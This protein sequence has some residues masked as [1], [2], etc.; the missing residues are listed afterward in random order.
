VSLPVL[1]GPG[2]AHITKYHIVRPGKDGVEYD[3]FLIALPEREQLASF[4]KEVPLF[5]RYLKVVTDQEGRQPAFLAFLERAKSGLVVESDVFITTEELL[6]LMWKNGYSEQ[7]RNAVQFTFPADYKFHYPELSVLFDI[8]EEDTYKFAMRTRIESSH[9]GELDYAK[10]KPK[11]MLRDHWLIFGTGLFIFKTFPFF[12][13]YFGVKVF[14]TSM[15]CWTVWSLL[16]RFV[17]KITRRNEYMAAQKTAQDVM[18]GEDAIV[19]SMRRFANDAK[20]VE[21]LKTFKD[22]TDAKIGHYRKALVLKLKDDLSE[23]ATKQ[24]QAIA[25][26]EANTG[27]ALQEL[28]VREAASSFKDKFPTTAALKD[29]AF[30]AALKGLAGEQLKPGED[31]VSVHFEDAFKSLQG[32]DLLK[33]KGDAKG[34]L[35]ERVAYAQQAK[36]KEF[37]QT[38]MVTADEV[39]EVKTLAAQAKAGADYDFSKLSADAAA[40]L[41]SLYTSINAKVGFSLPETLGTKP[42][43]K[44]SDATANAYVEQVNSQLQSAAKALREAR[45]KAFVQALA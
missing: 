19:K 39:Q 25:S 8:A 42:I 27:S 41:D 12:N 4:T 38:F 21:Y 24:L 20:C 45:L 11:G 16:N 13:Y 36:E 15:W 22:D 6:A 26:F 28:V 17:A 10:V 3:D 33:V 37:Q 18:D 23:R 43:A 31:P 7:E 14:G 1:G 30:A 34:S 35:P 29:K 9:I 44:T 40:R 32:I 5:I 2:G